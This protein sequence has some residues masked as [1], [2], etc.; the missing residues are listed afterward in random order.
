[1]NAGLKRVDRLPGGVARLVDSVP[2]EDLTACLHLIVATVLDVTAVS[3]PEI[4]EAIS[5]WR[6]QGG[7]STAGIAR[8]RLVA[9]QHDFDA[10]AH[11]RRGDVDAQRDSFRRA[12]AV[13]CRVAAMSTPAAGESLRDALR[14]SAY[15][16]AAALG[17]TAGVVAILADHVM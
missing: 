16:A 12:R 6:R 9:A 8:L 1:M 5:Q 15:E 7:A 4:R 11:Q 2:D 3:T 14:E 10:F 17:G 13:D